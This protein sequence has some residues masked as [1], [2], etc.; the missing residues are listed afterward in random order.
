V[1]TSGEARRHKWKDNIKIY[2][3]EIGWGGMGWIRLIEDRDHRRSF[4]NAGNFIV[5]GRQLGPWS[6]IQRESLMTDECSYMR[7]GEM[8]R[9]AHLRDKAAVT[10]FLFSLLLG[11]ASLFCLYFCVINVAER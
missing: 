11:S 1:E 8:V 6:F 2:H 4:L 10:V 5:V 9:N 7:R 3:R